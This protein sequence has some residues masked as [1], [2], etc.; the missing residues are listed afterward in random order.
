M[1]KRP[2]ARPAPLYHCPQLSRSALLARSGLKRMG[3]S[4]V[5]KKHVAFVELSE[6]SLLAAA[7]EAAVY[8]SSRLSGAT[9]EPQVLGESKRDSTIV[10]LDIQEGAEFV[11]RPPEP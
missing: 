11:P 7:G 6:A 4:G 9:C 3:S 5:G 8:D 1:A 2:G 10:A